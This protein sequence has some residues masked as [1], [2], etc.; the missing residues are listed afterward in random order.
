MTEDIGEKHRGAV[1]WT[2]IRRMHDHLQTYLKNIH[3]VD[4]ESQVAF[5]FGDEVKISILGVSTSTRVDGRRDEKEKKHRVIEPFLVALAYQGLVPV[6]DRN[7]TI[8]Y[9]DRADSRPAHE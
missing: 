5:V 1:D 2:V 7:N 3:H 9:F 4:L 8:R 6:R